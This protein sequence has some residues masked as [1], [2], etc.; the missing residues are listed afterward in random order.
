[1]KLPKVV[2]S[3]GAAAFASVVTLAA[4][5]VILRIVDLREARGRQRT[6]A[7]LPI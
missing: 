6:L 5:E 4:L 7:E 2:Q 3:L 1:M